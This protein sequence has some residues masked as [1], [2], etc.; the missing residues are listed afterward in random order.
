MNIL[1]VIKDCIANPS[2]T[3]EYN[4]EEHTVATSDSK[5]TTNESAFSNLT[6]F[7]RSHH[8]QMP[9]VDQ[10]LFKLYMRVWSALG[11]LIKQTVAAGSCFVHLDLG[12]FYPSQHSNK[13][14]FTPAAE[15]L[16]KFRIHGDDCSAVQEKVRR[17][18]EL[19]DNR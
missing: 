12:Y 17:V 5:S 3:R 18:R 13:F 19:V 6:A 10:R 9:T 15:L 7:K 11:K 4:L 1:D 8:P 2:F 16:A 14:A